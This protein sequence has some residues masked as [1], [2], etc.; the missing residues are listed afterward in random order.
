[1]GRK[2]LAEVWHFGLP[3]GLQLGFEIWAF[4]LA[5]L[6][7]GRLGKVELAAHVIA[8]NLASLCYM[9]PLGVSM[10]AVTRVGNLIGEGKRRA[11]QDAAWTAM[12]M[13]A[14]FMALSAILIAVFR[15]AIPRI[16]S[17][18]AAVI[19][20]AA[21]VLPIAAAFQVFDG[22]QAVGMGILRSMGRTRPAA[23]FNFIGYYVLALPLAWWLGFSLKQGLPGIWWGLSL[24]LAVIA[25]ALVVWVW[26][27]GPPRV[28]ARVVDAPPEA[29][30]GP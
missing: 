17:S 22:T 29:P 25:I 15:E 9:V 10:A 5:T 28:D 11:A 20:A 7:A 30:A 18:D 24:G 23:V 16:Y 26:R 27:R 21:A 4:D 13:G 8:L 12:V 6:F 19:A 1:V 3:V 14:G 2:G